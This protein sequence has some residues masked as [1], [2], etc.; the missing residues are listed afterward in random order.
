MRFTM[1][2]K[3][4]WGKLTFELS[5]FKA[6]IN[7][8]TKFEGRVLRHF[9][10]NRNVI[11]IFFSLYINASNLHCKWNTLAMH[12]HKIGRILLTRHCKTAIFGHFC[13]KKCPVQKPRFHAKFYVCNARG[14][15]LHYICYAL[16]LY[17]WFSTL[18][19]IGFF[20]FWGVFCTCN[21]FAML[22]ECT[23]NAFAW[24]NILPEMLVILN[25]IITFAPC[26]YKTHLQ[27]YNKQISQ[28]W[29]KH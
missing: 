3:R 16:A 14:M 22:L 1:K 12:L 6:E 5:T 4:F 13:L 26:Y 11:Y 18:S 17:V 21:A 23:C 8:K 10:V 20:A 19:K 29:Y 24:R 7:R 15:H 2:R 9:Y 28:Q 27:H 25:I